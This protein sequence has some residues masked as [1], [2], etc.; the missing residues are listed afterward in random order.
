M[1]CLIDHRFIRIRRTLIDVSCVASKRDGIALYRPGR[2][3]L[4]WIPVVMSSFAWLPWPGKRLEELFDCSDCSIGDVWEKIEERIGSC[5]YVTIYLGNGSE[6]S[7]LT[8]KAR[9]ERRGELT[10]CGIDGLTDCRRGGLTDCRIDGLS[11]CAGMD[12]GETECVIVK[13]GN[14]AVAGEAIRNEVRI[15][16]LLREKSIGQSVNPTISQSDN[17]SIGQSVDPPIGQSV[18]PPIG[19]SVN[20]A[21]QIPRVIGDVGQSGD[22]TWSVQTVLPRGKSPNHLQKEHFEFL[23]KLKELGISHGDFTPWNCAIVK[24]N[25]LELSSQSVNPSIGRSVNQSIGRSVNQSIDQSVNSSIS[26]SDTVLVAWDWEDA[27]PWGDGKD[28][29]WF[30]KQV[31]VL[32]GVDEKKD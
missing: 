11:D 9:L 30:R 5:K 26:Q 24:R 32:L 13:L 23:A 20:F 12:C 22:W 16:N 17:Q 4:R 2:W 3:W 19:Q 14:T 18:N 31:R 25:L 10:D 1:P 29:K 27:G 15:L 21:L 7:K 28:E 8:I 6:K